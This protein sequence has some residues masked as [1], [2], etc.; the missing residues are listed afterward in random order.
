VVAVTSV[1]VLEALLRGCPADLAPALRGSSLLVPGPRVQAAARAAGWAGP[2][3]AAATAEDDAM[4]A[5]LLR[6]IE[7]RL[8]GT[9]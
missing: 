2:I 3:V 9:C 8:P 1:E 4:L 7:G 6:H 5:T